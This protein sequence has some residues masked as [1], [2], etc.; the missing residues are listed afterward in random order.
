MYP[1]SGIS[2]KKTIF[3]NNGS[4]IFYKSD[5]YGFNN[6]DEEW[7]NLSTEYFLIGDSFVHGKCVDKPNDISSIL[8]NLTKKSLINV[9]YSGNG[10]LIEY[11]T[12]KEYLPKNTKN[13]LWFFYEGNDLEG[14]GKE[15]KSNI[16]RKYFLDK[17][18]IQNLKFKQNEIDIFL[19]TYVE[20]IYLKK[21]KNIDNSKIKGFFSIF[22]F[23]NLQ[24]FFLTSIGQYG[25]L[26][27]DY[28]KFKKL[29]FMINDFVKQ[30]NSKLYFIYLPEYQR[31]TFPYNNSNYLKIRE[32]IT[33]L[34]IRFID[35]HKS[36]FQNEINPLTLFPNNYD[37]KHY[38]ELGYRKI[39]EEIIKNI[40]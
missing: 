36:I 40:R 15:L 12:L 8:R 28:S 29:A 24:N 13:V 21:L 34:D 10:P 2:N 37:D 14:M 11:A 9:S 32:I 26:K 39:S 38:N 16:L 3:C 25:F 6:P 30:N 35:I 7:N 20:E 22:K 17:N 5:R 18:Y 19:N 4:Y 31:Y 27:S 23:S 33:G 1:L